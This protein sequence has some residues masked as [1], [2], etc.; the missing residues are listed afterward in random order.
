MPRILFCTQ[1]AYTGGGVE[2]WLWTLTQGL[3]RRRWEVEVALAQGG[4]FHRPEAYLARYPYVRT[5]VLA[6]P[7]GLREERHLAVRHLIR[8]LSPDIVMPVQL[9]DALYTAARCKREMTHPP[10]LVTCL[11]SH[12]SALMEDMRRCAQDIDLA[13]SVSA[14]GAS[15]LTQPGGLPRE[16]VAHIPTGVPPATARASS[17]AHGAAW[18]VGYVG[19]LEEK[20]K[21]V[22]DFARMVELLGPE[23]HLRFHV[24]GSGPMESALRR[25]LA[26]AVAD[27]RVIFHGQVDRERLYRE[28]YPT[29]DALVLF[30]GAEGGPIVAWEAMAHGVVPVV[31][32]FVGRHEEGVLVHEH[33]CFVFPV[34][35]VTAAARCVR[36]LTD[37]A[38]HARLSEQARKLPPAYTLAGFEG[39]WE[40]HLR[41]VLAGPAQMGSERLPSPISPGRLRIPRCERATYLLRRW[42]G[43]R[44]AHDEPGGEWPHAYG[45]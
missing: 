41:R 1:T 5:H 16:R 24:V 14:R 6:A 11:H 29:L 13:V 18:E 33:N 25:Q 37:P 38:C 42:A 32:D 4:R 9:A 34:G 40:H 26:A 20:E 35:D 23:R 45:A 39:N 22:G 15:Q 2:E 44:F 10:R 21:R 12:S 3:E 28:M 19:R 31:S 36:R 8:T 27:G 17:G 30:S 7:R 43:T